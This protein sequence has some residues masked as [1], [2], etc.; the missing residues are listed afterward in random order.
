MSPPTSVNSRPGY[1]AGTMWRVAN[2]A[3]CT[4]RKA[5][6]RKSS[7]EYGVWLIATYCWLK[8]HQSRGS[9]WHLRYPDLQPDSPS[10]RSKSFDAGNRYWQ[11]R[12]DSTKSRKRVPPQAPAHATAPAA[13]ACRTRYCKSS[14]PRQ[15]SARMCETSDETKPDRVFA[16]KEDDK[17]RRGRRFGG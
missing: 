10:G 12:R 3:N 11:C 1:E 15:V 8:L 14:G 9:R 13:F 4:R 5:K 16:G 6:K 7:D 2:C 17:D